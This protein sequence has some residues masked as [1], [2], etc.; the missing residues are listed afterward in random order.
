MYHNPYGYP[1]HMHHHPYVDNSYNRAP[2]FENKIGQYYILPKP[3]QLP[4]GYT[5]PANTR[6]FIH[7]VTLTATGEEL[8]TLVAPVLKGGNWVSETIKDIP[9]S[10]L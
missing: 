4:S 3:V 8:V 7:N 10:Q 9:A 6:V 2:Q 5:I 1:T